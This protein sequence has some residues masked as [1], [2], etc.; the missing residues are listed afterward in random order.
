LEVSYH[1]HKQ[2]KPR[3]MVGLKARN[4]V[5]SSWRSV[6]GTTRAPT[7]TM[8]TASLG[9]TNPA[10]GGCELQQLDR[11]GPGRIGYDTSRCNS[12]DI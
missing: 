7:N 3:F 9:R 2:A 4:I 8:L 11:F 10:C 1:R 5:F 6:G 12:V